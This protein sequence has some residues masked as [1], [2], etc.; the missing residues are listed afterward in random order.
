MTPEKDEKK[1]AERFETDRPHLR[2]V[3]YRMLGSMAEA[4]DAVQ[5]S[6]LR[7]TRA[8]TS[9]VGN[10]TGWLTTVVARIALDMLR[11]RKA[12]R[13]DPADPH[14][15]EPATDSDPGAERELSDAIGVAMLVVLEAL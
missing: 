15:A 5:E 4:E 13:E 7:L 11:R 10:L 8:D 14:A 9:T 1:L 6:W 2:Q 3:A 12:R